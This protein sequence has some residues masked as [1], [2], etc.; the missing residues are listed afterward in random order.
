MKTW[1]VIWRLI[2]FV[3]KEFVVSTFGIIILFL[4]FQIP[5]F[6]LREFFNLISGDAP[7][8]LTFSS[9]LAVLV[10]TW[11]GK[12]VAN[13]MLVR[14]EVPLQYKIAALLQRNMFSHILK[15]PGARALPNSP[16]E[17]ISRFRG[18]VQEVFFFPI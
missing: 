13:V 2:R 17:S 1:Q 3:P 12:M 9:I 5:A 16:G 7:A 15:Q 18:D 10:A 14:S 6:A 8:R 4:G 11:V